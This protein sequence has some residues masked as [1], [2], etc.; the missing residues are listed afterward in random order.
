MATVVRSSRLTAPADA[1]W[2]RVVTPAGINDE[3]WPWLTMSMPKGSDGL[4]IDTLDL[5]RPLGR[6]WIR[7]FGIL[8]V[9]YDDLTIAELE[10]GRRFLERS[11][12]FSASRWQHERTVEPIDAR[13]CRVTDRLEFTPRRGFVIGPVLIALIFRYRHW[14]LRRRF[15]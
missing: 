11:R 14:R 3:F 2:N 15:G 5:G 6:A 9:D 8:P 7:L 4:S 10:P 12:L 13:T 1:V